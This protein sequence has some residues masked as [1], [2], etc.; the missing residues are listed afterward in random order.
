MTDE[1]AKAI[2]NWDGNAVL[3]HTFGDLEQMAKF[4]LLRDEIVAKV[5][6]YIDCIADKDLPTNGLYWASEK[7]LFKQFID[8]C[9]PR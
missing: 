5:N 9:S 2:V 3:S 6:G 4:W 7:Q 1:T 8:T